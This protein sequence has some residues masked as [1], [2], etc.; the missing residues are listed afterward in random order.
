MFAVL[1]PSR[2]CDCIVFI[3]VMHDRQLWPNQKTVV[4]RQSSKPIGK[5]QISSST[6]RSSTQ[7]LLI[8]KIEKENN[9]LPL[10]ISTNR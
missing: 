10:E 6:S 7:R 4:R 2:A 3:V 9:D 1:L 8:S 5:I